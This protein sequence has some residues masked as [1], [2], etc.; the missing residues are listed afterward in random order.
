MIRFLPDT[1][2]QALLRFFNMVAPDVNI[3]MEI[4][5][6]DLRFAA[7]VLLALAALVL[8]RKLGPGRSA[9]FAM[10]ALLLVSSV[11]W[12][13][14]T[15]NG[16]YFMALLVAAGP[17]AVALVCLLPIARRYQALLVV[18]M[19][20]GQG[21]LL[22]QQTPWNNWTVVRWREAPYFGVDLGPEEKN[23]PP[24]TYASLQFLTYSLIAPQ[25]PPE[26]RWINLASG[27]GT[28]RDERWIHEFLQRAA[29]EGPVKMI[30]PSLPWASLPNGL[31][32]PDILV[33]FDALLARRS[34]RITGAC[35]HIVSPG[36]MRM[37][38]HEKRAPAPGEIP[39][40]FWTCP[41]TYD[42]SIGKA[43]ALVKPPQTVLDVFA[44][45]GEL[46]P[47]FFPAGEPSL[48]RLPDGWER[49]YG[50]SETR[51]YVMDNGD[52]WYHFWRSLNPVL[53]GKVPELLAGKVQIDCDAIR[54]DGAWR[55]GAQ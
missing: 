12:L 55:T 28:S 17:I 40:G 51:V 46:C 13:A 2:W 26:S 30:A 16:R 50:A 38:E 39:L 10:L 45:L 33:A 27:S 4:P 25:F 52:V 44:R 7:I 24:T 49:H 6:P 37:A 35:R 32:K 23:A 34:L 47:R 15:G 36:L 5:A 9:T 29:A 11:L 20:A 41:V 48:L 42:P 53:V 3:Y 54:S 19:L 22:S 43:A 21:F 18:L 31:P 8:W 14:T 1:L